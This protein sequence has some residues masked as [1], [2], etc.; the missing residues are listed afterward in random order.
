[1]HYL[2]KLRRGNANVNVQGS[3]NADSSRAT[4]Q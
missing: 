1:M 4:G 2:V 3:L